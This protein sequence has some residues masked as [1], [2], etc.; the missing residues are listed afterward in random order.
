VPLQTQGTSTHPFQY[1]GEQRDGESGFVYLRAR[2]YDPQVGRFMSRDDVFGAPESPSSLHRYAYVGNNPVNLT[3]PS[4]H[5]WNR[6]GSLAPVCQKIGDKI[7]DILRAVSRSLR[8]SYSQP[9][10]QNPV[11]RLAESGNSQ[12]E[13]LI[14]LAQEG[15]TG[16]QRVIRA[17]GHF[18]DEVV[19]FE[20]PY[21]VRNVGGGAADILLR[22]GSVVEVGGP[23]K[24]MDI[25]TFGSQIGTLAKY[26]QEKGVQAYFMYEPGTPQRVLDIAARHV[27]AANVIP[28]P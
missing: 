2:M 12:A 23:A 27:G 14:R 20:H 17:A 25:S 5:C 24:G 7:G 28:I 6:F 21:V 8:G 16:A 18:G 11:Q 3:D 22:N 9:A 15:N 26:A 4:G 13:R 10:I 1:T 19:G